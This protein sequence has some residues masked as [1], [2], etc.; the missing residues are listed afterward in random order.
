MGP[1]FLISELFQYT[2][3]SEQVFSRVA[4]PTKMRLRRVEYFHFVTVEERDEKS[5]Y[6][7]TENHNSLILG[8]NL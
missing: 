3:G 7:L 8:L 6:K 1:F 4:S 5:Q 2:K